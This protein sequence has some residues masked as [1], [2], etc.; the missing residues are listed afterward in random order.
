LRHGEERRVTRFAFD[1]ELSCGEVMV[2]RIGG[3]RH[4]G[5]T[6]LDE[7]RI[8]LLQL[9]RHLV[10]NIHK[11]QFLKSKHF[12]AKRKTPKPISFFFYL[13]TRLGAPTDGRRPAF[14]V[15][16]PV[17]HLEGYAR[18]RF[19]VVQVVKVDLCVRES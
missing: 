12:E 19:G 7:I 11:T 15:A 17:L 4:P 18:E 6:Y 14:K 1:F 13:R 5:L 8:P 2:F 9:S 3:R 10:R 16:L